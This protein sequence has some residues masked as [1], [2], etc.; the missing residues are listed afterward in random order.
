MSKEVIKKN[1]CDRCGKGYE[2]YKI[3]I[4]KCPECF[5]MF[6]LTRS[7]YG[8]HLCE[9]CREEVRIMLPKKSKMEKDK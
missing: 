8:K 5:M 1:K 3:L 9:R 6:W 2:P 7:I 4:C